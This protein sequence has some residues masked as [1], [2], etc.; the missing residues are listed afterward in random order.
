ML[1]VPIAL[2]PRA[3][4][5]VKFDVQPMLQERRRPARMAASTLIR[6]ALFAS[7]K[8]LICVDAD[9]VRLDKLFKT[10]WSWSRRDRGLIRAEGDPDNQEHN[11]ERR[12]LSLP[13]PIS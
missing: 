12:E 11:S 4:Q 1:R 6:V 8:D 10:R 2:P 3:L 9:D 7:K 13:K 5:E